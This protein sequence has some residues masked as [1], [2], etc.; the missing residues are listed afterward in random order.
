M[1]D[2]KIVFIHGYTASHLAD[3]YPQ[4]SKLLDD[5]GVDY[6]IPDLPGDKKPHSREWL[7][8]I[9]QTVKASD[10]PVVLFGHSL[11]TR[12]ALLY[13]DQHPFHPEA[14]FLL[15]AFANRVENGQ[16]HRGTKYPDFFEYKIDLDK[17]KQLSSKFVVIHSHDDDSIDFEQGEELANDLGAKLVPLDGR[18]HMSDPANAEVLFKI[19]RAELGF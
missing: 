11:G 6:V 14:V 2:F 16:R 13:L 12:A 7:E 10:K 1:S 19:L 5:L 4:I 18:G 15:A 3:W 9:D 8:V 17:V